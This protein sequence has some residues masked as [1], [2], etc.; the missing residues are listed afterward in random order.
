MMSGCIPV[1]LADEIEF[2]YE[3]VLDWR[4][5]TVKIAEVDA[6][7]TY[8]ILK[9]IPEDAVKRKQVRDRASLASLAIRPQA[10]REKAVRALY[11]LSGWLV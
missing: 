6:E 7:K 8:A 2:P 4:A 1:V 10:R 11:G 9:A 5:L 3:S